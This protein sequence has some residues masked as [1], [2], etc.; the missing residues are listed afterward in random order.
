MKIC[1]LF[2]SAATKELVQHS[3]GMGEMRIKD[4]E[5]D[6]KLVA[7]DLQKNPNRVIIAMSRALGVGLPMLLSNSGSEIPQILYPL[8]D[9]HRHL[10]GDGMVYFE[11]PTCLLKLH[12]IACNLQLQ[13]YHRIGH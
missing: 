4:L 3:S 5:C 13:K 6:R 11:M 12:F 1:F 7:L 9:Q 10:D 8:F 2:C